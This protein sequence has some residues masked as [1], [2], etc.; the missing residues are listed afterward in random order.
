LLAA[1]SHITATEQSGH[2]SCVPYLNTDACVCL[3]TRLG[4]ADDGG[5]RTHCA[6][7]PFLGVRAEG[8]GLVYTSASTR[9]TRSMA[10]GIAAL[11][12]SAIRWALTSSS[13]STTACAKATSS[14]SWPQ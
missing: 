1:L 9:T 14:T 3:A 11:T 7:L 8:L 6:P 4:L 10:D 12:P 5:P 13:R 2:G